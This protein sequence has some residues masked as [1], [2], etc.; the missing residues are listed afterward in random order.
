MNYFG[1]VG[2]IS[3]RNKR[4]YFGGD[5]DHDADSGILTIAGESTVS[6]RIIYITQGAVDVL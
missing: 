5:P 3:T 2:C 6:L 1:W 4:L